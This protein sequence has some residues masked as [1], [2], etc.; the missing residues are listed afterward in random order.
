[1]HR[2]NKLIKITV[3][4][5]FKR[6]RLHPIQ[7]KGVLGLHREI[8]SIRLTGYKTITRTTTNRSRN[9]P[10]LVAA[11]SGRI[12]VKLVVDNGRY[13]SRTPILIRLITVQLNHQPVYGDLRLII[14][15]AGRRRRENYRSHVGMLRVRNRDSPLQPEK[16]LR[17]APESKP[18]PR[19]HFYG[20]RVLRPSHKVVA[21]IGG[22][23]R[24]PR[25]ISDVLWI[26]FNDHRAAYTCLRRFQT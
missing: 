25:D 9:I 24:I 2:R 26:G 21:G 15:I 4:S 16:I 17:H 22:N 11:T 5:N 12:H 3:K 13:H 20:R 1:V 14:T 10:K 23:G 8:Q 19:L 7:S 6:V 18:G